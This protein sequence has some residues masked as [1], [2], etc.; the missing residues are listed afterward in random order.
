MIKVEFNEQDLIDIR[1][2]IGDIKGAME[3]VF[4][5]GINSALTASRNDAKDR[6]Y[7]EVMLEKDRIKKGINLD[8][9]KK[10]KLTGKI[11]C[12]KKPVGLISYGATRAPGGVD[13]KVFRKAG[14]K[15]ILHTFIGQDP[16]GYEH[17][18]SR[19]T[20]Y[21]RPYKPWILYESL[22]RKWRYPVKVWSGSSI[23]AVFVKN[24][25]LDPVVNQGGVLLVDRID[26]AFYRYALKHPEIYIDEFMDDFE[27]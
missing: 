11:V 12:S 23:F 15:R 25:V 18:W 27:Y 10:T 24:S 3:T 1:D 14:S 9:A 20:I 6:I 5:R 21:K 26:K 8:R 16:R 17:V 13:V 7:D 19:V 2:R 22:P 4:S